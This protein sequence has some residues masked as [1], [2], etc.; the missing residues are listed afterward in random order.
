MPDT[1][2]AWQDL[3]KDGMRHV[4]HRILEDEAEFRSYRVFEPMIVPGLLQ[5]PDYARVCLSHSAPLFGPRDD[6]DEAVLI[7]MQRQEI[8]RDTDRS[9]HF[10]VTEA[11]LRYLLCEPEVMLRQLGHLIP[12]CTHPGVK[13]GVIGFGARYGTA[14][15][16]HGFWL[17]D[18]ELV[19]LETFSAEINISNPS[20]IE[21]YGKVFDSLAGIA[22]YGNAARQII[23]RAIDDLAAEVEEDPPT[24]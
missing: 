14:F 3:L 20:E 21:V 16:S 22:S 12:L 1:H 15:P 23:Q 10:I 6:V 9:F 19:T 17:H 8:L 24:V 11:A 13:L 5:L 18:N 4:Q 2:V 7:R